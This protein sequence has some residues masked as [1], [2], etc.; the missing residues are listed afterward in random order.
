MYT[1]IN[2]PENLPM[3][4]FCIREAIGELSVLPV[5]AYISPIIIIIISVATA[6]WST[7]CLLRLTTYTEQ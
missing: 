7:E 2:L 5:E 1:L 3:T 4:S 6:K